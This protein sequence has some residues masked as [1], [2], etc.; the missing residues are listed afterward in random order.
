[1]L[2][3]MVGMERLETVVDTT[4][5][6]LNQISHTALLRDE[7]FCSSICSLV[8]ATLSIL[9]LLRRPQEHHI[10]FQ[11]QEQHPN[12][13]I[14]HITLP[15][16]RK[17]ANTDPPLQNQH[18][19]NPPPKMAPSN[20]NP[21]LA[22][23]IAHLRL[24]L[25]PLVP[26]PSGPPHPAFPKTLLAY[27]LL[28]EAELDALAH[29]YHQST[30]GAYTG[31]YPACMNW[32]RE[33]LDAAR[34]R[35]SASKTEGTGEEWWEKFLKDEGVEAEAEAG[36]VTPRASLHTQPQPQPQPQPLSPRTSRT[37]SGKARPLTD[38]ERIAIKR[39]KVGKFIGL[40]GMETPAGEVEERIRWAVERARE[41]AREEL[42]RAEE[43]DLRRRKML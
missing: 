38:K 24:T 29:Y 7:I 43:W 21:S 33:W 9:H 26:L 41:V 39:R 42:R 11:P 15:Y 3:V 32:D 34:G 25:S 22:R 19:K 18:T 2:S 14:T 31:E 5:E 23:K 12:T 8:R 20:R 4:K 16:T 35:E 17:Q 1:M 6:M 36:S 40:V 28:T 13:P 27:H 10:H 37:S 30:P